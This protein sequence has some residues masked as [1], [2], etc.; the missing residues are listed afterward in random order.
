MC[1]DAIEQDVPERMVD[2]FEDLH[3]VESPVCI[4]PTRLCTRNW[5]I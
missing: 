5:W 3:S 4:W 2:F 1:N